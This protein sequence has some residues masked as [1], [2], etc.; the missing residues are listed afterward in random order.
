M[1]NSSSLPAASPAIVPAPP[2][3]AAR[4]ALTP[5]SFPRS[6]RWRAGWIRSG[7]NRH[8]QYALFRREFVWNE[9]GPAWL[10]LSAVTCYR[11]FINGEIVML[12]GGIMSSPH[13]QFY[14]SLEV[15]TFLRAGTNCLGVLVFFR[16]PVGLLVPPV[17]SPRVGS[18]RAC[19]PEST[20]EDKGSSGIVSNS[21]PSKYHLGSRDGANARLNK[22][23]FRCV[24]K[25][26]IV[27]NIWVL[28]SPEVS[29]L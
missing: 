13:H 9:D 21:I 14:D 12:E 7:E 26:L 8:N 20:L 28:L 16:G 10:H 5:H 17:P 11:L 27:A 22:F 23:A 1:M 25:E 2:D 15:A 19:R 6:R 18:Q 3:I 29:Y 4:P 24:C